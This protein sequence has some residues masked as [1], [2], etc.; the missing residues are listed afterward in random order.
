MKNLY[1]LTGAGISAPSGLDTYIDEGIWNRID[2][3][4]ICS[5]EAWEK[6]PQKVLEFF[7]ERRAE[8]KRAK[9]NPV[10][11]MFA[12]L[13]TRYSHRIFH[14]TQNIDD[15]LE[16]AGCKNIIHL[17]GKLNEIRCDNCKAVFDIGYEKIPKTPCPECG[18][19]ALRHNVVMFNEVAPQYRHLYTV[20]KK[21][22][23]FLCVG[24]SGRVI[25][26]ADLAKEFELS[27]LVDPVRRKYITV[28]G[29][30][31][32]YIDSFFDVFIQKEAQAA[33][34]D[35]ENLIERAMN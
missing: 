32:R 30:H 2:P 29:E 17:H 9:P 3:I 22:D 28:F 20:A 14:L 31:D 4:S 7:D 35:I 34:E 8:L 25:D 33:L 13:E 5:L 16:R 27:I 26:I 15:L 11:K 18:K 12:R 19:K 21:C 6:D 23:I 10:H 24:T 1:I